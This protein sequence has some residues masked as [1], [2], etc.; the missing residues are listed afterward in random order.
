MPAVLIVIGIVLAVVAVRNTQGDLATA[1]ETDIPGFFKWGLAIGVVG[2]AGYVPGLQT[3]SRWL[4]ALILL[5]IVLTNYTKF[6]AGFTNLVQSPP[7]G[8]TAAATPSAAYA[9]NPSNPQITQADVTGTTSGNV[10]AVQTATASPLGQFDP[11]TLL[12][13][14]ESNAPGM[15]M[16]AAVMGSA[17]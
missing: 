12:T 5:V 17:A 10:N 15:L 9:A 2:G 11:Q 16:S 13:N 8:G 6:F 14:F 7:T 1:L 4:L 3:I